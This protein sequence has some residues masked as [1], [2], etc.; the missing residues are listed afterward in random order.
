MVELLY[1]S[2]PVVDRLAILSRGA[3]LLENFGLLG[4][5]GDEP[6]V[7]VHQAEATRLKDRQES[8]LTE[9]RKVARDDALE[10][11]REELQQSWNCP[12]A[13]KL[14]EGLGH[15][16]LVSELRGSVLEPKVRARQFHGVLQAVVET[17]RPEAMV[18]LHTQQVLAASTYLEDCDRPPIERRGSLNV[19]IFRIEN[20]DGNMIMDTRGMHEVGLHDLQCRFRNLD[21]NDVSGKLRDLALHLFESGRVIE[22]GQ[23]VSG[24]DPDEK[25][26]CRF[27]ESLLEPKREILDLMPVPQMAAGDR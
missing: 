13:G 11:Y 17:T 6:L 14:I 3:R 15:A 8:A 9:I 26:R 21:P 2:P 19:R 27:E 5:P 18:F 4:D 24:V 20:S 22:S 23:T 25:F 1:R 16:R 12:D 7:Y 10:G